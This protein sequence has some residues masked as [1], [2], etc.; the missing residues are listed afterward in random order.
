MPLPPPPPPAALVVRPFDPP[1]DPYAA[2]HRGLD[3]AAAA[4]APVRSLTAGRVRFAGQVAGI[5]VVTIGLSDD[6]RVTYQPVAASVRPGDEVARGSVLGLVPIGSAT[7]GHCARTCL[8][9][10]LLRGDTYLDPTA[11][12]SVRPEPAVLKPR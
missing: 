7:E 4:G 9:V 11:L 8:H 3:L 5:P 12:L 1:V 6:R 2:G 10:G